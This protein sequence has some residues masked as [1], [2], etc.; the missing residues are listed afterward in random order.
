MLDGLGFA[1]LLVQ[2]SVFGV[3]APVA[4]IFDRLQG[5]GTIIIAISAFAI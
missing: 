3:R 4:G 1:G 2:S 5:L